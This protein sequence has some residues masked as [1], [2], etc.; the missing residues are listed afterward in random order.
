MRP[1]LLINTK[2]WIQ[3]EPLITYKSGTQ[4]L[5]SPRSLLVVR[6]GKVAWHLVA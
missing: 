5:G 3:L 4:V 2:A 6:L 1:N